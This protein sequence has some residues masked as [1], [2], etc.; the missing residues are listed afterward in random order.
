MLRARPAAHERSF[1]DALPKP[2]NGLERLTL[3][4]RSKRWHSRAAQRGA[5]VSKTVARCR[6]PSPTG[7]R[8]ADLGRVPWCASMGPGKATI[9]VEGGYS[10][11]CD[12]SFCSGMQLH[13]A[14]RSLRGLEDGE[15]RKMRTGRSAHDVIKSKSISTIWDVIGLRDGRDGYALKDHFVPAEL[16]LTRSG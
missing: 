14:R 12:L 8:V 1:S 13:L 3:S 2:Y 15:P 7:R 16:R 9:P 6:R 5:S 10:V 11:T 4:D